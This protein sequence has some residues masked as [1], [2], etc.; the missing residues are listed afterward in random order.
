MNKLTLCAVA[1]GGRVPPCNSSLVVIGPYGLQWP[2]VMYAGGDGTHRRG[3]D[4]HFLSVHSLPTKPSTGEDPHCKCCCDL[5]LEITM[6]R[7]AGERAPAFPGA[8]LE[9]LV[10]GVLPQYRMLYG[11]PDQQ[12]PS[13]K[14]YMACIAKDVRTLGVYGRRSTHCRK[15]WEDLRRGG[16]AGDGLP[17][18]KGSPSNPDPPDGPHTGSGLSEARWALEGITAATRG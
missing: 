3:R 5:C 7:V 9:R 16:P 10:D 12:R 17:T 15:R 11:S 4:C 13:E 18:R 1:G 14:G 6:A 8:E 2:M